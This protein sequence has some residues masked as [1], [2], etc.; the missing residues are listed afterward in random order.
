MVVSGLALMLYMLD[1]THRWELGVSDGACDVGGQRV[2]DEAAVGLCGTD[3]P[4]R[5]LNTSLEKR[6]KRSLRER[7]NLG[8]SVAICQ[9]CMNMGESFR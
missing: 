8:C 4:Q 2:C 6:Q 9:D 5:L 3:D 1:E 7:T